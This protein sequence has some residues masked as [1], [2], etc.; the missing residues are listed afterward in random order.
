MHACV[1]VLHTNDCVTFDRSI[2]SERER[3]REREK[4]KERTRE[5]ER[6]R[7]KFML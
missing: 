4:G 1:C 7:E 5:R 6:E 2:E 3:K